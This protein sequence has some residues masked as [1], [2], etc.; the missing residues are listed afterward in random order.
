M[1]AFAQKGE[2]NTVESWNGAGMVSATSLVIPLFLT[3]LRR[4]GFASA[5][6]LVKKVASKLHADTTTP[7]QARVFAVFNKAKPHLLT[8]KVK[9]N[10]ISISGIIDCGSQVSI[11][12]LAKAESLHLDLS[13]TAMTLMGL[14]GTTHVTQS[15]TATIDNNGDLS[16]LILYVVPDLE[17][18][19]I[20]L[21]L[22]WLRQ[23]QAT[24]SFSTGTCTMTYGEYAGQATL[25]SSKRPTGA[26]SKDPPPLLSESP[27]THLAHSY[28]GPSAKCRDCLPAPATH[29]GH[30]D[31]GRASSTP[32]PLYIRPAHYPPDITEEDH[33]KYM[34]AATSFGHDMCTDPVRYSGFYLY[35]SCRKCSTRWC[36]NNTQCQ[37]K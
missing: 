8:A 37:N 22:D 9:V 12:S 11:I 27:T 21:G 34:V 36:H 15:V 5:K 2:G 20:L 17:V 26:S 30:A 23:V 6:N 25:E 29:S 10:G 33:E 3:S 35:Y 13:R 18:D 31:K 28:K 7:Q 1:L 24:I 4:G 32:A 16:P 19:A 14:D